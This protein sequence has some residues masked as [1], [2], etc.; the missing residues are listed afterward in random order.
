MSTCRSR[1]AGPVEADNWLI[2]NGSRFGL[3]Q[4]YAN[5]IWHFEL[6]ADENGT[7]PSLRP[8]GRV[9]RLRRATRPS[10][11]RRRRRRRPPTAGLRPATAGMYGR[12]PNAK[13]RSRLRTRDGTG[14]NRLVAVIAVLLLQRPSAPADPVDFPL[15]PTPLSTTVPTVPSQAAPVPPSPP[16]PVPSEAPQTI[17][18]VPQQ[19]PAHDRDR[20]ASK[21]R[22]VDRLQ[23]H[24]STGK[25]KCFV[26]LS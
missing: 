14:C 15:D 26:P 2:R 16:A 8:N 21:L 10:G 13:R 23:R 3:C 9:E 11:A 25:L 22:V 24:E 7:C 18:S 20:R 4:I 17:E 19:L 6:A 1:R 12:S 5:E